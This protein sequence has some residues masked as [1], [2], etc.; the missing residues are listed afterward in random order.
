[1]R[2]IGFV[3]G[4]KS[5]ATGL[6]GIGF[7][8]SSDR[9][10]SALNRW[11][12]WQRALRMAADLVMLNT[13]LAV[14]LA[15]D[16][17]FRIFAEG[18]S[19]PITS[20]QQLI[21]DH[22]TVLHSNFWIAS[23]IMLAVMYGSGFY[24]HGAVYRRFKLPMLAL[25]VALFLLAFKAVNTILF[26]WVPRFSIV[27]LAFSFIAAETMFIGSRVWSKLWAKTIRSE[28]KILHRIERKVRDVLVIGGGGYIGS[29]L[30]PK[31]L[32]QGL[33]VKLLDLGL[34]G[35]DPIRKVLTHPRLKY[36]QGDFRQVD[37]V[38]E[39]MQ[40][41]DA[42]VHL[43]GI[44]GDP[45]CAVNES[46]TVDLNVVS[47]RMI[48]EA[49]KAVGVQRFIFAST[50][51]VYGA[52]AADSFLSEESPLSPVS[53]Y[54]RSKIAS[55]K[56]I[57]SMGQDDFAPVI[58][59]F[60]TIYG[61]SGRTRFDLVV[62]LLTAMAIADKKITVYG[63]DQWRPFVHVEDAAT[64]VLKALQAPLEAV[65]WQ[66]LNVG[67]TAENYRIL[68]VGKLVKAAVPDAQLLECVDNADKRNYRVSFDKIEKVLDFHPEWT[69][70]KG[71]QQVIEAFA[72]GRI[73]DYRDPMFSNYK[74]LTDDTHS[75]LVLA[76]S[77]WVKDLLADN[78]PVPTSPMIRTPPPESWAAG[79]L[80]A[81]RP[82][83][84]TPSSLSPLHAREGIYQ[85]ADRIRG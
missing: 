36:I 58:L 22:W 45:A 63:G 34:F 80:R 7:A 42:V 9:V 39:A 1:M 46:L 50:C 25:D 67:S 73:K 77:N 32:D 2:G 33:N 70:S 47:T 68:D 29:A 81:V 27:A 53:L 12:P 62:N 6:Q 52:S 15:L 20:Y 8:W 48:A 17:P 31:L 5:Q 26:L 40:D 54:A 69:V 23:L 83:A 75:R 13:A 79:A 30:L 61:L 41:T 4:F 59:R 82:F 65:A 35:P 71:I 16:I 28:V 24:T 60:G 51:S 19:R 56:V 85:I 11:L 37:I 76:Y 43:G 78:S 57:R 55:E 44:V 66:T 64:A 74:F 72:S 14:G 49:A 21:G 10:L 18:G 84:R 38:V 3:E